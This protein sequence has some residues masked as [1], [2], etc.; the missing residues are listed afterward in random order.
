VP[1]LDGDDEAALQARIQEVERPLYVDAVGRLARG[2]GPSRGG[3]SVGR[4]D[5]RTRCAGRS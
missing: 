1:V 5:S 3:P 2:A 4:D